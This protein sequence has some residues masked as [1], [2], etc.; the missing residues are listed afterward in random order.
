MDYRII[1][2]GGKALYKSV[3]GLFGEERELNKVTGRLK[4]FVDLIAYFSK[5]S[6]H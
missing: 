1:D 6:N 5:V 4:E 3:L 2:Q